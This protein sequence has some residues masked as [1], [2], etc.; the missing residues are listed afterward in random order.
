MPKKL[1]IG[2]Q[3]VIEG[4]MM[5][6]KHHVVT[7]IR[8]KG[9]IIFKK[10]K[11]KKHPKW[12]RFFFIRGIVNLFEMLVIGLKTLNW[13]ASEQVD[14]EE[15]L[16]SFALSIT[17]IVA[18]LFAIGLF[19]FLP[20]VLTYLTGIKET[21]SPIWFN[22]IDGL[23]KSGILILY[24][25]LI[26]LMKDIKTVFKYHG[27]EHK[28][29]FCYEDNKKLTVGNALKYSTKHPRCGTAFLMIVIILSIFLFSFIPFIAT[30]LAPGIN[31]LNWFAR[32]VVLFAF[33]ILLLPVVAGFSYEALK[34]GAKHQDNPLFRSLTLPGLWIQKIT[35]KEPTKK[36]LEVAIFALS[37]V[38]KLENG[39]L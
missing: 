28:A 6:S 20:Y 23:I 10:E 2:G 1:D 9:N 37:K 21:S 16:S 22:I 11:I 33:R 8:K 27:A 17:M 14:K 39:H 4:V 26:S 36:Q 18:F 35:T 5:R 31:S 3:A 24:L 12:T 29:V 30:A 19:V 32:R 25:Y 13:S 34:F 38:L 7:A 15:E